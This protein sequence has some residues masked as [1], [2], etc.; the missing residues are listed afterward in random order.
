MGR[1]AMPE[2][3][4]DKRLQWQSKAVLLIVLPWT[5]TSVLLQTQWWAAHEMT[6]VWQALGISAIFGLIVW[7]MRAA[8]PG[9]AVTG[10]AITANLIFATA[11]FPYGTTWLHGGLM[12]LL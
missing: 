10:T 7:R 11:Q 1:E 9:G 12:P 4:N 2:S 8:T 6:V 5:V 3:R